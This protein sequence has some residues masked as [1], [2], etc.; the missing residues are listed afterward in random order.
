MNV[1]IVSSTEIMKFFIFFDSL[2][3]IQPV[4][5]Y[6]H[7]FQCK[8]DHIMHPVCVCVCVCDI[9][10]RIA[11]EGLLNKKQ[12]MYLLSHILYRSGFLMYTYV[13]VHL[14]M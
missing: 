6:L 12:C 14:Y 7:H 13:C 11:P 2:V 8:K 10:F 9:E 3:R 4:V 1:P 5:Y